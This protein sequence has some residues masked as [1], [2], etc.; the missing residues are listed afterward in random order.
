ME[1]KEESVEQF[2][3]EENKDKNEEKYEMRRRWAKT[4]LIC[5]VFGAFV[6]LSLKF[7][8][9]IISTSKSLNIQYTKSSCAFVYH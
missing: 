9:L 2:V 7:A 1:N 8:L 4:G 6:S 5:L 3:M